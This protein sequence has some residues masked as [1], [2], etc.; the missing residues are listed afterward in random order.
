MVQNKLFYFFHFFFFLVWRT[1]Y[2][3]YNKY[4]ISISKLK[5]PFLEN[6]FENFYY[7][8]K[9]YDRGKRYNWDIG[10]VLRAVEPDGTWSHNHIFQKTN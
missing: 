8:I 6:F 10:R 1:N 9:R 5:K 3:C 7:Y 4:G 2:R